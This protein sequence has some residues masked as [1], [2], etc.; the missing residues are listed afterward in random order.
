MIKNKRES[1]SNKDIKYLSMNITV[2]KA[3][4]D[5]VEA[6][7]A[8]K[9]A[10]KI[11]DILSNKEPDILLNNILTCNILKYKHNI[12]NINS[13]LLKLKEL[14]NNENIDQSEIIKARKLLK[15]IRKN[16][17]TN[18]IKTEIEF[19]LNKIKKALRTLVYKKC[20]DIQ[21]SRILYIYDNI[22]T[23]VPYIDEYK[24]ELKSKLDRLTNLL[25]LNS[26]SKD[27]IKGTLQDLI[28]YKHNNK[29][30]INI[31]LNL[32]C[33]VNEIKGIIQ[34]NKTKEIDN[35]IEYLQERVNN[36]YIYFDEL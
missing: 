30:K 23:I 28:Q 10:N 20:I 5:E 18:D 11:L 35:E 17:N 29:Y 34:D 12:K 25:N 13:L 27:K 2:Q 32:G 14:V 4:L 3:Q 19:E 36:L 1:N 7:I 31:G 8:E 22:N 24:M 16:V 26:I 6:V 33:I 9:V 21:P 15:T